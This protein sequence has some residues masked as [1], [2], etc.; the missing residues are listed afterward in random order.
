MDV[1]VVRR[2]EW[3]VV[4]SLSAA[5][6]NVWSL[7]RCAEL[8]YTC[9]TKMYIWNGRYCMRV[10]HGL[11]TAAEVMDLWTRLWGRYH[12]PQNVFLVKTVFW[13]VNIL[14]SQLAQSY[15]LWYSLCTPYCSNWFTI[16]HHVW[17]K[18]HYI[19][20]SNF[21]NC[22]PIIEILSQTDLAVNLY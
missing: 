20:A 17:K 21:A 9:I 13:S 4:G 10:M 16:V 5:R 6:L 19:F 2:D 8:M 3:Q 11:V 1:D 18:L 22:C 12:V 7:S 14:S 15:F